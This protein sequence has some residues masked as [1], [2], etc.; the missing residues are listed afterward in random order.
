MRYS[1]PDFNKI[2]TID[3][4]NQLS[5]SPPM[6]AQ[7]AFSHTPEGRRFARELL[8]HWSRYSK[9]RLAWDEDGCLLAENMTQWE[10]G[11]EAPLPT[12][13]L[14]YAYRLKL[15]GG[16]RRSAPWLFSYSAISFP[17]WPENRFF[18]NRQ[19]HFSVWHDS[20]GL[21]LVGPNTRGHY[22]GGTFLMI[23]NRD[24][25]IGLLKSG[26]IRQ[27][28][29]GDI[30]TGQYDKYS[31]VLTLKEVD[32]NEFLITGEVKEQE[33][34][35]ALTPAIYEEHL[36][37][38]VKEG[39]TLETEGSG[40]IVLTAEFKDY[41]PYKVGKWIKKGKWTLEI[42]GNSRLVW[43]YNLFNSY[44]HF[45]Y[46]ALEK[47][48]MVVLTFPTPKDKLECRLKIGR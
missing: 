17:E 4:R 10:S 16:V 48:A 12:E 22:Y 29:Q 44:T 39:D 27:T 31:S 37:L 9:S 41:P 28:A 13:Q 1:Y 26:D 47:L 24:Q 35:Y 2:E 34:A 38:N 21:V 43:P 5:E 15:P 32:K 46:P 20:V 33:D 25:S 40:K 14:A 42:P 30:V 3:G 8:E 19:V 11:P 36:L 6:T 18:L 7:A 23:R 45:G